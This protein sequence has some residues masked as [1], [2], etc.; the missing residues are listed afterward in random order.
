MIKDAIANI[1][2]HTF[3]LEQFRIDTWIHER[4]ENL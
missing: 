1:D 2:N 4:I 3:W